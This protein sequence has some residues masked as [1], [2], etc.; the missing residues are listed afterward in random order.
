[1]QKHLQVKTRGISTLL[2]QCKAFGFC[3]D[4]GSEYLM[5]IPGADQEPPTVRAEKQETNQSSTQ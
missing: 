1:M 5:G 3:T 4:H 2:N